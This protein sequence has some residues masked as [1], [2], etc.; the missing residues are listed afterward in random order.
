[1]TDAET[2]LWRHLRRRQMGLFR[3][4]RGRP[5]V[6]IDGGQHAAQPNGDQRRTAWL[7]QQGFRVLRFWNHDVLQRTESVLE[8]M[9]PGEP[10]LS[11]VT[12]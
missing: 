9:F 8:R 1:M 3:I 7:E 6:E 11:F 10:N 5:V 12:P 4:C 2:L